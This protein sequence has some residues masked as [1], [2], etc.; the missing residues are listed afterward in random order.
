MTIKRKNYYEELIDK[1][2]LEGING[3]SDELKEKIN[4]LLEQK[5]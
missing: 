5:A 2:M 3:L 1:M 4:Q